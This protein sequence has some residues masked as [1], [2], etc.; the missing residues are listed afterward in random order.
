M[1]EPIELR[2][3]PMAVGAAGAVL[4]IAGGL[5][6]VRLHALAPRTSHEATA[7]RPSQVVEFVLVAPRAS[8]VS[9]A[10]DFNEWRPDVTPMQRVQTA[11]RGQEVWSVTIPVSPGRHVYG[12]VIDGSEWVADPAAPLAPDDGFGR[13][14]SVLVVG[15]SQST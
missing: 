4:V 3:S 13:R 11:A 10:G 14:A 8:R 6:G 2:I 1:L 9:L 5:L 15:G 12:F 7:A